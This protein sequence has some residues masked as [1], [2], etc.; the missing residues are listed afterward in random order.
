MINNRQVPSPGNIQ[1]WSD[2]GVPCDPTGRATWTAE[3][4]EG[5]IRDKIKQ[6]I[7]S[8]NGQVWEAFRLFCGGGDTDEVTPEQFKLRVRAAD[9]V[10]AQS[11]LIAVTLQKG[12]FASGYCCY[13]SV[14]SRSVLY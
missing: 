14:R 6:K 3:H 7:G 13:D 8:G 10:H 4:L 2:R 11:S 9:L 1:G 5:L 12:A